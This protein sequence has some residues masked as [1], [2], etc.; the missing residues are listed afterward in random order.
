MKRMK[1]SKAFIDPK[2]HLVNNEALERNNKQYERET[3]T[4]I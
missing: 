2:E 3:I 4:S 1:N